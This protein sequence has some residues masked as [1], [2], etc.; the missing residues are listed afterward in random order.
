MAIY[1]FLKTDVA[2][3]PIIIGIVLLKNTWHFMMNELL[4]LKKFIA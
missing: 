2:C 3:I 4:V 1:R